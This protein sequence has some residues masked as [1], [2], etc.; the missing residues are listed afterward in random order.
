MADNNQRL[1]NVNIDIRQDNTP[2]QAGQEID[3]PLTYSVDTY[4][5]N[6][7]DSKFIINCDVL[8][9]GDSNLKRMKPDIMDHRYKCQYIY[10]PLLI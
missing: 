10:C 8:F 5:N 9:L 1:N 6:L 3:V 7:V 4:N 2:M